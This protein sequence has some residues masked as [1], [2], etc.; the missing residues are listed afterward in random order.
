L[1]EPLI[2]CPTH[3]RAGRIHV[4]DVIPDIPLCVAESQ[5][6]LYAA[7]HPD[8]ELVVHPDSVVGIAPKRQWLVD[9][10]E[11]VFMFDDDVTAV[12]DRQTAAGESQKIHDPQRIR[13]IVSRLFHMG[14]QLGAYVVG[15][16]T[17][18]DPVLYRP[19]T[20]FSFK[21]MISGHCLGVR[22][23]DQLRFPDKA[24]L[25]TDDL[26]ISALS[27]Y[28]HRLLLTDNR[29]GAGVAKTWHE[30]GGMA[31][32]RTW[33][34]V[35]DNER[36]LTELFGDSIRRRQESARSSLSIEIQLTLKVPW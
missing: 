30:T 33:S 20:P 18:A 11:N 14:E 17:Y 19:H 4:F 23:N 6:P 16:S 15:L 31:T 9:R 10:Y 13:D 22:R 3:G 8:A 28:Y 7:A 25:L 36:Y 1:P 35:V 32:H 26:W 5:A 29:Y 12:V 24:D 34:K 21:H 2:I 27:A